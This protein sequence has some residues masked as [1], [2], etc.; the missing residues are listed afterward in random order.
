MKD[1]IK[2]QHQRL[3]D[4]YCQLSSGIHE[5]RKEQKIIVDSYLREEL[6]QVISN[7]EGAVRDFELYSLEN[8]LIAYEANYVDF[9]TEEDYET[10]SHGK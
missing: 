8:W 5:L 10:A 7:I 1:K 4:I 3:E 6:E 9:L 2:K